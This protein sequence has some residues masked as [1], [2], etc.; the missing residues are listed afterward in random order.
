MMND[1]SYTYELCENLIEAAEALV[2]PGSAEDEAAESKLALD[3][4]DIARIVETTA[5]P[6]TLLETRPIR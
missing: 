5:N 6:D 2:Q 4:E 1:E 3:D